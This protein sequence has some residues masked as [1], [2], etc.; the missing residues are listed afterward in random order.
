[1]IAAIV[2]PAGFL[3]IETTRACLVLGPAPGLD[4]AGADRLRDTSLAVFRAVDRAVAFGLDLGLVIGSSEVCATPSAAPPQPRPGKSPG[5]AGPRNAPFQVTQQRSDQTRKPV[6][7]EQDCCSWDV[8]KGR[9]SGFRFHHAE[10][11]ISEKS[12]LSVKEMPANGG[13]LRF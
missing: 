7:S 10:V 9:G 13:L 11:R 5:R 1:M 12:P 8:E 3:S 4:D 6:N 2:A